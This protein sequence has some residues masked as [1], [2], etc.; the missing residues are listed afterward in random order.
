MDACTS[1]VGHKPLK[2]APVSAVVWL[3][4]ETKM[5]VNILFFPNKTGH[6]R[7]SNR[8]SARVTSLFSNKK[9]L[10]NC[11]LKKNQTSGSFQRFPALKWTVIHTS[12]LVTAGVYG[13]PI[14]R[15][16]PTH[17]FA[18]FLIFFPPPLSD[19]LQFPQIPSSHIYIQVFSSEFPVKLKALLQA[20]C[21]LI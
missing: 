9:K 16:P 2:W 4:A 19:S 6:M 11:F 10:N 8:W 1:A 21:T 15:A 5:A 3:T 7:G 18:I 20:I 12:A 17:S 14:N 13:L